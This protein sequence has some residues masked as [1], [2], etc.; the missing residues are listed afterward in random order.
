MAEI[1][2]TRASDSIRIPT[3]PGDIYCMILM[4]IRKVDINTSMPNTAPINA[5]FP[6]VAMSGMSV[7]RIRIAAPVIRLPQTYCAMVA[8]L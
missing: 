8:F 5:A 4:I 7:P 1:T 3:R 2:A 6:V